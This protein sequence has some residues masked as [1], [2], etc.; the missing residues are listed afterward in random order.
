ME[1]VREGTRLGRECRERR[2]IAHTPYRLFVFRQYW[3]KNQLNIL[4][5]VAEE[6]LA[7]K[8]GL[9]IKRSGWR[10]LLGEIGKVDEVRV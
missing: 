9:S 2:I 8:Q 7:L 6:L 5:G 3:T 4:V 10:C 1:V